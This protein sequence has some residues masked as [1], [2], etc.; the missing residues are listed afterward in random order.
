MTIR[1]TQLQELDPDDPFEGLTSKQQLFV[2]H[3]FSGMNDVEAYRKAYDCSNQADATVQSSASRA[4]QHPLVRAKL[5]Q[6]VARREA[7][8]TLLPTITRQWVID[9]IREIAR[10]K[11]VK[12]NTRLAAYVALGKVRSIDIFGAEAEPT[13]PKLTPEDMDRRILDMI[14]GMASTIEGEAKDISL[15]PVTPAPRST[16]T[17]NPVKLAEQ[18]KP[19]VETGGVAGR[20][21]KP[22]V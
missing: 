19:P 15:K 4:A 18:E 14:R 11:N 10:D 6:L 3:S 12:P 1:R 5:S 21:R 13:A 8:T 22:R 20:K 9:G 7:Q 17:K 16:I 2:M